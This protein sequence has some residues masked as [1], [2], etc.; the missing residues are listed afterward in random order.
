MITGL[1]VGLFVG[2]IAGL[3]AGLLIRAGTVGAARTAEARLADAQE[4]SRILEC[5]LAEARARATKA[6]DRSSHHHYQ[7]APWHRVTVD[8]F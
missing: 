4:R 6:Q 7:D 5:D 2:A 3:V 1:L 8:C